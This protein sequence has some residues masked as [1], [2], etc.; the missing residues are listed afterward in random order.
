[1]PQALFP[2]GPRRGWVGDITARAHAGT[3][4]AESTI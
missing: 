4:A 3:A 2:F 1:V